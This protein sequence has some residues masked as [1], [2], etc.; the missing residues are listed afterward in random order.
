MIDD[1][2][3]FPVPESWFL[4]ELRLYAELVRR[5]FETAIDEV[6]DLTCWTGGGG[7]AARIPIAH[8]SAVLGAGGGSLMKTAT[9]SPKRSSSLTYALGVLDDVL[10]CAEPYVQ[11]ARPG[12]PAC[13]DCELDRDMGADVGMGADGDGIK[14]M[15]ARAWLAGDVEGA[16]SPLRMAVDVYEDIFVVSCCCDRITE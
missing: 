8:C 4:H 2:G 7:G 1:I 16:D 5:R 9:S 6:R 12:N 3:E 11:L 13:E 14:P 10:R 15:T